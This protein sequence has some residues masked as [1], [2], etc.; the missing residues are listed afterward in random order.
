MK[1][2][3]YSPMINVWIQT[4]TGVFDLSPYVTDFQIDRRVNE[5]SLATVSFRNPRVTDERDPSK[6]RFMFTEHIANDGTVRPMFHPMD[7]ITITLTRLK[8]RPIQVFTGYCDTTPYV[9][10][11][12]GIAKLDASCT[13]KRLEYTYWDPALLFVRNFM[14]K[15]GWGISPQG[16]ALSP[17]AEKRRVK[18][19][20]S[21]IGF[22]L[23]SVLTEIGGWSDKNIF[24]QELPGDKIAKMVRKL[25]QDTTRANN[26][27]LTDFHKFL[28][29]VIGSA[30][31][32]SAGGGGGGGDE[33]QNNAATPD[34]FKNHEGELYRAT[35]YGPD[36]ATGNMSGSAMEGGIGL[37]YSSQKLYDEPKDPMTGP[38]VI[39]CDPNVIP[40][41]TKVYIWPNPFNYDGTFEMADTG[42]AFHTGDKHIDIYNSAGAEQ[43]ASWPH[44]GWNNVK[45]LN[46]DEEAQGG[47]KWC[48][49]KKA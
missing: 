41:N 14:E 31:Y 40:P 3:I 17:D 39:A 38:Y 33:G 4:D 19:N 47:G 16:T 5:V 9:Q 37:K 11:K 26:A 25:Y 45:G 36:P 20:D 48:K 27:A 2:L 24:I 23:Y 7:P 29:D 12:P 1:R 21:S 28:G 34:W 30:K 22:L 32:G 6:T 35:T 18:N 46:N 8:G 49:V 43:T 42:G 44:G 15:N 10:L 13:L